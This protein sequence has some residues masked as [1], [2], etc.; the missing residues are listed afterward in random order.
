LDLSITGLCFDRAHQR[1]VDR[2][3]RRDS[4]GRTRR[5]SF[6]LGNAGE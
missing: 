6:G 5:R 3:L 1:C 4:F 2:A